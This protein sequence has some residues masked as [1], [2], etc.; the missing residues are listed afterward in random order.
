MAS[1]L[2][3]SHAQS[4]SQWLV[5]NRFQVRFFETPRQARTTPRTHVAIT[6]RL[7]GTI[8]EALA[9]TCF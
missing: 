7:D 4:V 2:K 3:K 8:P 5:M 1:T 6:P 9:V